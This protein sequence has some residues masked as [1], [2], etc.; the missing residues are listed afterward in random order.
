MLYHN[1]QMENKIKWGGSWKS[2]PE[3]TFAFDRNGFYDAVH[4]EL[5]S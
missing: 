4:F 2:E 1:G 3:A 5:C